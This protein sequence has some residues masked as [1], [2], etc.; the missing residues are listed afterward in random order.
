MLNSIH[1]ENL[2]VIKSVDIDFSDGF[3]ALFGS[4]DD[5]KKN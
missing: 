3:S 2:A 1:I 4:D 5:A